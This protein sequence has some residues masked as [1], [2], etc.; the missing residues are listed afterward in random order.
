MEETYFTMNAGV[1]EDLCMSFQLNK[2]KSIMFNKEYKYAAGVGEGDGSAQNYV[3]Y[4]MSFPFK[5]SRYTYSVGVYG[6][7][8]HFLWYLDFH[9]SHPLIRLYATIGVELMCD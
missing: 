6:E 8:M 2:E 9:N 7:V 4:R 5:E 1:C 3:K